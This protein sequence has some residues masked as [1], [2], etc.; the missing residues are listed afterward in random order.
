MR[1]NTD[2]DDLTQEGAVSYAL[3][4]AVIDFYADASFDLA[5]PSFFFSML[6]IVVDLLN[7]FQ[8]RIKCWIVEDAAS[9]Y[10]DSEPNYVI[11]SVNNVLTCFGKFFSYE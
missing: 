11:V 6:L 9:K 1:F 8:S 4:Q 7:Q 2:D 3:V 5:S 10:L